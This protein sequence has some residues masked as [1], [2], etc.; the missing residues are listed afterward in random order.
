MAHSP[1]DDIL[2][3]QALDWVLRDHERPL[4][5]VE[6]ARLRDWLDADETHRR[7]YAE[8]RHVWL[9]TGMV[10]PATLALSEADPLPDPDAPP[11]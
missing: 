4:D 8:A 9:L 7:A 10:P 1:H 5:P 11:R 3:Q 2:W 6:A